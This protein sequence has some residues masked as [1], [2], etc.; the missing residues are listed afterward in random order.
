MNNLTYTRTK[1]RS[2]FVSTCQERRPPSSLSTHGPVM[3][4]VWEIAFG[5]DAALR[6]SA[7][8]LAVR[9]LETRSPP[10]SSWHVFPATHWIQPSPRSTNAGIPHPARRCLRPPIPGHCDRTCA[11]SRD[12]QVRVSRGRSISCA[13]DLPPFT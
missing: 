3:L 5:S 2:L 1:S 12:S 10:P 8:A 4:Q 7:S 13:I 11:T 9:G 6:D